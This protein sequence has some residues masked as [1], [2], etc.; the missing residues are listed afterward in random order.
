[1]ISDKRI[2]KNDII[3]IDSVS[4]DQVLEI[5]SFLKNNLNTKEFSVILFHYDPEV[6]KEF[7]NENPENLSRIFTSF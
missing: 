5:S 4:L 7:T 2:M 6:I 1:M 3:K